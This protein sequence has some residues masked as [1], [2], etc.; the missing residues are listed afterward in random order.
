M[1]SF[2]REV[3]YLFI[4]CGLL[5]IVLLIMYYDIRYLRKENKMLREIIEKHIREKKGEGST[6]PGEEKKAGG[7]GKD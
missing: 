3:L 7:E 6:D 2:L 4:V 5:F 1:Y